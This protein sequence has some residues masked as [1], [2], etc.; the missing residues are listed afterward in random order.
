MRKTTKKSKAQSPPARRT[1]GR[2]AVRKAIKTGLRSPKGSKQATV[3]AM[4]RNA[5]GATIASLVAATGWQS[6]S[7]RG[8]FSAV[9]RKKLGLKLSSEKVGDKRVYRI[10]ADQAPADRKVARKTSPSREA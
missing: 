10:P 4:L 1:S 6:H 9:V 8:F 2:G 7:I 5:K 3:L